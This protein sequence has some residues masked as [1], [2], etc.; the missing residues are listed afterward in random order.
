MWLCKGLT[1]SHTTIANFRKNNAKA[2]K[3]VFKEFVLLCRN[4][5]LIGNELVALDGAFLR[6]NASKNQ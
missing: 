6:A 1:P 4:L 3:N 5:D 2:L